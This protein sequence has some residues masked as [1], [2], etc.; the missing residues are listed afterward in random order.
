MNTITT[1]AQELDVS[2]RDVQDYVARLV[3]QD[4]ETAVIAQKPADAEQ[5]V[6]TEAA[7]QRVRVQLTH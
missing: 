4:G 3:E 1:L 2:P 5:T 6:L 7:A